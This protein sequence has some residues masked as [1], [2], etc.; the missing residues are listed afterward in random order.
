MIQSASRPLIGP[1]TVATLSWL[2]A[3][4]TR[5]PSGDCMTLA[6]DVYFVVTYYKALSVI[7]YED[8]MRRSKWKFYHSSSKLTNFGNYLDKIEWCS[9]E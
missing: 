3:S 4:A 9:G 2:Y 6:H 5:E 7:D 1:S 8:F